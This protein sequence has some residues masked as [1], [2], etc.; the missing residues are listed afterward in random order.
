MS[1]AAAI[2]AL[3]GIGASA[4]NYYAAQKDRAW[5]EKMSNTAHQREVADLRAAGL[6]PILSA[7]GGAGASVPSTVVP[8]ME[9]VAESAVNSA[10][11][12]Q[13]VANESALN[14]LAVKKLGAD[15]EL[16]QVQK[17]LIKSQ[18]RLNNANAGLS[19]RSSALKAEELEGEK[20]IASLWRFVNKTLE[21]S[22]FGKL[23]AVEV[24]K[25]AVDAGYQEIM[26]KYR[27]RGPAELFD[28]MKRNLGLTGP[29]NNTVPSHGSFKSGSM[30]P[31]HDARSLRDQDVRR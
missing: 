9:N 16:T 13:R 27:I 28:A 21:E 10:L 6:N 30:V 29:A 8:Q 18:I 15:V 1:V 4:F 12:E 23:S 14:E 24:Y 25:K 2:T 5:K 3:G 17:E 19:G 20:A 26:N 7:G 22:G 11:A 31:S